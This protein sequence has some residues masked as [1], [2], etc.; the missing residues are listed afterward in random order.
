MACKHEKIG[1]HRHN[2][3]TRS[4]RESELVWIRQAR[5]PCLLN[6]QTIY[7]TTPQTFSDRR[8]N[9][10]IEIESNLLQNLICSIEQFGF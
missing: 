8:R 9:M 1:I 3:A 5:T 10:L 2:H 4:T 6:S 7:S